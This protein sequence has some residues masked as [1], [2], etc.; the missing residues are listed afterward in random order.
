MNS[1]TKSYPRAPLTYSNDGGLRVI[2]GGSEILAKSD[3][4]GSMNYAGIFLGREKNK[5]DF[6]GLRKK[7]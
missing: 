4:G 5:R 1:H 7:N 6:L 2:F 3:F